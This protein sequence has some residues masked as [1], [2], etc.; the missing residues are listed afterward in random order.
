MSLQPSIYTSRDPDAPLLNSGDPKTLIDVLEGVLVTGYGSGA[1]EKSPLGWEGTI[2]PSGTRAA[3]RPTDP[4]SNGIWLYIDSIN[5]GLSAAVLASGYIDF[6]GWLGDDPDADNWFGATDGRWRLRSNTGD[7]VDQDWLIIGNSRSF[8]IWV[9]FFTATMATPSF[10]EALFGVPE[11][12]IRG[13][14]AAPNFFGDLE[15]KDAYNTYITFSTLSLSANTRVRQFGAVPTL[16]SAAASRLAANRTGSSVNITNTM[17][18]AGGSTSVLDPP[19][20]VYYN[21]YPDPIY[22]IFLEKCMVKESFNPRMFRGYLPGLYLPFTNIAVQDEVRPFDYMDDIEHEGT[23][24]RIFS[25]NYLST[26][27]NTGDPG[28]ILLELDKDWHSDNA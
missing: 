1:D 4:G 3:F 11:D 18:W 22:G 5:V 14:M 12:N 26:A 9:S 28:A 21:S 10:S 17:Y 27:T 20:G 2:N 7:S 15:P 6:H 16:S 23:T 24:Y 13:W 19:G 25:G 8:Y